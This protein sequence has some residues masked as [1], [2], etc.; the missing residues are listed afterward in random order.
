MKF[1]PKSLDAIILIEVM[2]H[3]YPQE[4]KDLFK[5]IKYWLKDDGFVYIHTEPNKLFNDYGYKYYSYPVGSVLIRLSNY[6]TG[7]KYPGLISPKNIRSGSHNIMHINEPT[8][9]NLQKLF[10]ETGFT[11]NI[12][13]S[14]ISVIKPIH[15][16]KD[17]LFNLLVYFHPLSNIY[18][19]NLL[20]GSDFYVKLVKK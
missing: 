4:Q 9:Q 17:T 6:L 18:P 5:K 16:W 2:E 3:L 15:S 14:G 20:F 1:A 8:Y 19:L 12:F 13:S 7:R 10:A 11:G